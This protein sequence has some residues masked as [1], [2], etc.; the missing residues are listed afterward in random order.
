MNM[1]IWDK[2]VK[3][4][5]IERERGK[6]RKKDGN[7]V[8]TKAS[9]RKS[10]QLKFRSRSVCVCPFDDTPGSHFMFMDIPCILVCLCMAC[11]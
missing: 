1:S 10:L 9:T 2:F 6:E 7:G 5:S 11:C 8:R 4:T 3:T